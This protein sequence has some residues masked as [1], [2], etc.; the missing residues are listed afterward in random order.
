MSHEKGQGDRM[1]A[2]LKEYK[3]RNSLSLYKT[4]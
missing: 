3:E 4:M 1:A 2:K